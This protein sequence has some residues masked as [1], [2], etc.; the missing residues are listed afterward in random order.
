MK[1]KRCQAR[2]YCRL[3]KCSTAGDFSARSMAGWFVPHSKV[4][5]LCSFLSCLTPLPFFRFSQSL[6]SMYVFLGFLCVVSSIFIDPKFFPWLEAPLTSYP[7]SS[8]PLL[9]LY[10]SS[11]V[12]FPL[13]CMSVCASLWIVCVCVCLGEGELE[14]AIQELVWHLSSFLSFFSPFRASCRSILWPSWL[15]PPLPKCLSLFFAI[16]RVYV[17]TYVRTLGRNSSSSSRSTQE[18]PRSRSYLLRRY[19]LLLLVLAVNSIGEN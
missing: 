15:L 13:S 5:Y 4:T 7:N 17:R 11:F 3:Q 10:F 19:L 14:E 8:S 6:Y 18:P 9:D 1:V 16:V 2:K 12:Y